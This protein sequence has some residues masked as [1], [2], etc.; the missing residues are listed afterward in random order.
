MK[1]IV[2]K[3]EI[4]IQQLTVHNNNIPDEET[5]HSDS[6]EANSKPNKSSLDD[7]I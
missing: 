5:S 2:N 3:E 1:N 7:F 4:K 6:S